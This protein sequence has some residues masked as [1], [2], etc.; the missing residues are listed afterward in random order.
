MRT[1]RLGE[2]WHLCD[3]CGQQYPES[4]LTKSNAGLWL[5]HKGCFDENENEKDER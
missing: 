1:K 5:C 2:R 3:R 4:R